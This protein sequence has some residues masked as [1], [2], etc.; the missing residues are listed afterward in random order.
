VNTQFA[1]Y[2]TS[3]A[4]TLT[5]HRTSIARLLDMYE[6]EVALIR[7]VRRPWEYGVQIFTRRDVNYL[8]RRGLIQPCIE[9]GKI[10]DQGRWDPYTHRTDNY[11]L[12]RPGIHTARLLL[13]AGFTPPQTC[14]RSE[15]A[16][17]GMLNAKPDERPEDAK[18]VLQSWGHPVGDLANAG[19]QDPPVAYE[20]IT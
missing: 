4:F 13:E 14:D 1:N 5:L 6:W 10:Y 8:L 16:M 7:R 3:S 20:E 18:L 19:Q 17:N 12:T 9:H 15:E 2:A 11:C